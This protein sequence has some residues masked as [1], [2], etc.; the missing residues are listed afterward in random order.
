MTA[1][2]PQKLAQLRALMRA[3]PEELRQRLIGAVSAGDETMG[4]LLEACAKD[5]RTLARERFFR[6]LEPLSADPAIARPSLSHAPPAML[7]SAWNW[8]EEVLAPDIAAAMVAV[9]ADPLAEDDPAHDDPLRARAA[10][11]IEEA[12]TAVKEDPRAGKQLR[13]RLGIADFR[14]VLEIA[15]ILRVAPVLREALDGL[16]GEIGDISEELAQ[17]IRDRYDLA[18]SKDPDA[19]VWFLYLLMARLKRPWVILRVF[20]KIVRRDDDFLLSR[21]DVAS[22]GD[23]MLEDAG[24]FLNGFADPPPTLDAAHEAARALAQ[25][26]QITIGMT[27]EI[28]IRK[29]GGWGRQIMALRQRAAQQMEA[30]HAEALLRMDK[31]VPDPHKPVAARLKLH[32]EALE[33]AASRAEILCVFI[34]LTR[35]DSSRAAAGGAHGQVMDRLMQRLEFSAGGI[36]SA[37]RNGSAEDH[38]DERAA[39]IARLMT[40]LGQQE[41]A[42]IFLRRTA[43]VRAA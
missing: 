11:R 20:E 36:L 23:A 19:G 4:R 3:V 16:P 31:A 13:H 12:V 40:A 41:A 27:R 25:F 37:L 28:G 21:T 8:I 15:V 26:A 5:A 1:L 32:G 42:S 43:A 33:K 38:V 30:I 10:A 17:H 7:E 39:V 18:Y 35:D 9:T 6:P 34:R 29:D 14:A 2:A 22:I 24:F